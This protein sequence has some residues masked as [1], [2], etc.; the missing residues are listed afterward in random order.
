MSRRF[1]PLLWAFTLLLIIMQ[2]PVLAATYVVAPF[3]VAGGQ[4]YSYLGQAVP[5]MLTSRLYLQGSFEPVAR[6]DAA[7][8]EKTPAST[9]EA[10]A[11]GKKFG[12]NYVV[13]GGITVMGDQASV[14]V[15][16]L[17]PKGNVWK[18]SSASS[19]NA[20]IGGLQ[21][22]ADSINIE[23]FGRTDVARSTASGG[24]FAGTPSTLS[25]PSAPSSVFVAN[26]THGRVEG[27]TYLNPS[28]RY[29]GVES[30]RAQIRSQLL[31]FECMGMEVADITGDGKNEVLLLNRNE[32]N[33]YRWQN[34]NK[35][36]EIGKYKFP[37]SM[38]PVLVRHYKQD[39]QNYVILT[40][41]DESTYNPYSQVL[42]FAGGKF[43]VVVKSVDRYLNV[44]KTPP[45]Y[46]S[47]L[48][49]Q[50]GDRS[51][52]VSGPIYEATVKGN[53]LVRN[54]KLA[55]LP[56][57]AT[58]FNFSWIPADKGRQGDHLALIAE[59]E[60]L[61]TFDARGSRLAGT[62]DIY[63][64]SSV[65]LVGDRGLGSIPLPGDTADL[66]LN[67]V[68]MRMPVVDLDRDGRYELIANKPVTAAGKLF[69][70]YRT[71]PQGEIHAMLWNGMGMELL[72]KTRR[73][74]GTVSDVMVTDVDNNGK[75]DLVVAVNAY[76]G[77]TSGLKT[78][79]AV[80]M[81]PLDTAK[82]N[83]RANYQE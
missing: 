82:V 71:Y 70:N 7:L 23:V 76:G 78:R 6:Q 72:W 83:A 37:A 22:V 42:S 4:G 35:L 17:S 34:G 9:S 12:A 64:G 18:K 41:F 32:I 49:M 1:L 62:E 68:P 3:S 30:E 54:G 45:L 24:S 77:V 53:R 27:D 48:I 67:Y 59:N 28:L 33:V 52:G 61:L 57:Q 74:K 75:I 55:N 80:Y 46:G 8:R 50:E 16:V 13:W 14:D 10:Q 38:H 31:N 65:Y 29:Q 66:V 36:V 51:K 25:A 11:L 58:L 60:T 56:K 15:S 19:V 69:A 21:A 2:A 5:S 44:V 39:G 40:G 63:G 79:C 73:I 26:E 43:S 81:Y 47:V 20:L